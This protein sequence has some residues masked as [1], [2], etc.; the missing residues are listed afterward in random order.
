MSPKAREDPEKIPLPLMLH[1]EREEDDRTEPH[2]A[3]REVRLEVLLESQAVYVDLGVRAVVT[4]VRH[5]HQEG[6]CVS[7]A[8]LHQ[9][10]SH[11]HELEACLHETG[12]DRQVLC[13]FNGG[14]GGGGG[15][16]GGDPRASLPGVR[17]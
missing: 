12:G 8:P 16:G 1:H 17:S 14:V 15:D 11:E 7:V 4:G 9:D 10:M 13:V 5:Q 6:L 3:D 2:P